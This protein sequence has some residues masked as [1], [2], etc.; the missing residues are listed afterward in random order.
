MPAGTESVRI[1]RKL[2]PYVTAGVALAALY[3]VY[4]F[5][6]AG[7]KTAASRRRRLRQQGSRLSGKSRKSTGMDSSRFSSSTSR[8]V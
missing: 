4:V 3:T 8:P 1:I 2:L 6:P 7:W 5:G